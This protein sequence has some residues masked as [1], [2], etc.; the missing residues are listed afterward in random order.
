MT[1]IS[2]LL[3]SDGTYPCY[4]GGVSVWCDQLIRQLPDVKFDVFAIAYSPSHV[5]LFKRPPNVVSQ[6]VLPLW[7][8]EEPG[9]QQEDFIP[10]LVRKICTTPQNIRSGFL[11]PFQACLRAVLR[12][13]SRPEEM[14]EALLGL[15]TYFRDFDFARTVS[16]QTAWDAFL[17]VCRD[18]YPSHDQP[19]LEE[20]T[21]CMRW[22]QRYLAICAVRFPETEVVHASMAGLAGVPGVIQKQV[23]G[24]R[25]LLTEHGIYLRELYMSLNRMK[26]GIRC[27]RFLFAWNEAIARMNYHFADSVSSLCEFNR[28][29]QLRV[30]AVAEKIHIIPNGID[31]TVFSPSPSSKG[32]RGDDS[33]LTVLTMA[34]IYPLKGID[35]LL[36][37]ARQVVDRLPSV[38]FRILGEV[39]DASYHRSC[40]DLVEELNL[41]ANIEWGFT[42][43]AASAYK[44]ADIFCLPSI[45]EAMPYCVLEAMFSGC[46]VVATDVGGVSDML[47]RTGLLTPPRDADSMAK[48]ILSLLEGEGAA[49]YRKDLAAKAI[50]RARSL[51]TIEKCSDR[52]RETYAELSR[53]PRTTRLFAA[54]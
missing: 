4:T 6:C 46:P 3:T 49:E 36:R 41:G 42:S 47:A 54:R 27:R 22:L 33:A 24:S 16:S 14:A 23:A 9:P 21:T 18:A 53:I 38:R 25:F 50:V 5:P 37:A 13:N 29:W 48:A 31:P 35:H 30:G 51:Y 15:H 1:P 40:L 43:D 10:N 26:Q 28:Q 20:A 11:D 32:A 2:V 52:F 39:G 19:T 7:G 12:P 34:R 45:S 44:E 8:T 17:R